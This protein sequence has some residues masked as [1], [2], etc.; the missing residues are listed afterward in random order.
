MGIFC[1][2]GL[3]PFLPQIS[4]G[5]QMLPYSICYSKSHCN[6]FQSQSKVG[7]LLI[8]EFATGLVTMI[9]SPSKSRILRV[10]T[11]RLV[12]RKERGLE[13]FYHP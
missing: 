7:P 2:P 8:L 4:A 3:L 10:R 5:L 12:K 1:S 11:Y 9:Q 13:G 6:M